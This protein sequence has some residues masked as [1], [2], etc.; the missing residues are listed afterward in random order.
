MPKKL[1]TI[2]TLFLTSFL[3]SQ[4]VVINEIDADTPGSD[5]LNLLN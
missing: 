4:T 2:L 3:F 1:L 5:T